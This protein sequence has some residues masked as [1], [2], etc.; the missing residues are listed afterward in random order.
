MVKVEVNRAVYEAI[1]DINDKM[2]S[3]FIYESLNLAATP[4]V[5]AMRK[6]VPRKT[7][8]LYKS[9]KKFKGKNKEWPSYSVG[10]AFGKR[11]KH[12]AYYSQYVHQGHVL[13]RGKKVLGK[14]EP[15]P[16]SDRAAAMA[17]PTAQRDLENAFIRKLDQW[18]KKNRI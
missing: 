6:E 7:D 15:N 9:I 8:N 17:L 12:D 5:K 2:K 1:K 11:A 13:K 3:K 16:F 10:P 18:R 4:I 14:V